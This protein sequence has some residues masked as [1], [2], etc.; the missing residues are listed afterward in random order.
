MIFEVQVRRVC[1]GELSRRDADM[2]AHV[3]GR[4]SRPAR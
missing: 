1:V 4:A 2:H 3:G